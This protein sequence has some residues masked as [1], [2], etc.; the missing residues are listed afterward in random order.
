MIDKAFGRAD[1]KSISQTEPAGE[2]S[3]SGIDKT[4]DS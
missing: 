2:K 1:E 3:D 4:E